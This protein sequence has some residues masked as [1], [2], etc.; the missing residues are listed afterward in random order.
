M[1]GSCPLT[2]TKVV[3]LFFLEHRAKLIDLAAFF[4]RL[5]R[6]VDRDMALEDFRITALRNALT[7]LTDGGDDRARRVLETLSDPTQQP[8]DSAAGLKGA[9]GA[10]V[11]RPAPVKST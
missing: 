10:W 6:A 11:E 4:D 3:E 9:H 7:V 5:D 2:Y 8:L 1:K